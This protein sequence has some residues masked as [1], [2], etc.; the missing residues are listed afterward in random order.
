MARR[1]KSSQDIR[2][3]LASIVFKVESGEMSPKVAETITKIA[4]A[5]LIAIK[6]ETDERELEALERLE[7]SLREE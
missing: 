4:N 1:L 6:T 2:R 5:M 7:D 3:Y